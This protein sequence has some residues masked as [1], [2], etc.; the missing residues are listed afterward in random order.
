MVQPKTTNYL[1]WVKY[2]GE[3]R[4]LLRQGRGWHRR[5][6]SASRD[7]VFDLYTM[8]QFLADAMRGAGYSYV[9]DVGFE[10]EDGTATFGE[11]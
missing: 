4:L 11:M 6:L 1:W 5:F 10:K 7:G 8:S 2:A 3:Y 9:T